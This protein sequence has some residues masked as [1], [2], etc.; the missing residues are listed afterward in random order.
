M[1]FSLVPTI[2]VCSMLGPAMAAP[3][4]HADVEIG[5]LSCS[6]NAPAAEPKSDT[7]QAGSQVR[8]GICTFR[9]KKGPEETY[10]ATVQGWSLTPDAGGTAIWRVSTAA[11]ISTPGFLQQSYAA[12]AKAPAKK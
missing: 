5:V 2:A 1:R 9:P 7:P 11:D 6:V 3:V 4:E 8:D 10:F 12:D